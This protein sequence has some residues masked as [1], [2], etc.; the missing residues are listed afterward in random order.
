MNDKTTQNELGPLS[1]YSLPM[2]SV[3]LII[4]YFLGMS[5]FIGQFLPEGFDHKVDDIPD[6]AIFIGVLANAVVCTLIYG[7]VLTQIPFRAITKKPLKFKF[8]AVIYGWIACILVSLCFRLLF[9]LFDY[10]PELQQVATR[11][12]ESATFYV[13][14][15]LLGPAL[16]I[17]LVEEILFRGFLYRSLVDF[18]RYPSDCAQET[19]S[20]VQMKKVKLTAMVVTSAIFALVHME[21]HTMPQL[22]L[23]GF[24]FNY[25]Y[26]KTGSLTVSTCLHILN[27]IIGIIL[28]LSSA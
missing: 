24:I 1:R 5:I 21:I 28:L 6:S 8:I 20:E 2:I 16:L 9:Y 10:E 23:L 7:L 14:A 17:P 22:F 4:L 19:L 26:E 13:P 12:A 25:A 27:N 11:I 18:Y 3:G 15:I